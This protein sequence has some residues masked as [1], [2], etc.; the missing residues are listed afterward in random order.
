MNLTKWEKY[1]I[2]ISLFVVLT[3]SGASLS[4]IYTP[5]CVISFPSEILIRK[6][7]IYSALIVGN[8]FVLTMFF[9]RTK[10]N[11]ICTTFV[12][13][14]IVLSIFTSTQREFELERLHWKFDGVV[15]KKYRSDN[16]GART[17]KVNGVDYEYIAPD[18]WD[19]INV[20]DRV[21]K[22]SCEGTSV[23]SKE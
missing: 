11:F 10:I 4:S 16:H 5:T 20:G 22:N 19:S 17:I 14:F 23:I 13:L 21:S 12:L 18:L 3:T 9:I 7:I 6:S 2:L 15:S 1:T 8:I